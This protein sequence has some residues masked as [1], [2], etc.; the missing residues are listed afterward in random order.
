VCPE[1]QAEQGVSAILG[2]KL[3]QP[4]NLFR[5]GCDPWSSGPH[6]AVPQ[7]P[8]EM[9]MTL[10]RTIRSTAAILALSLA[11]LGAGSIATASSAAA[12]GHGHGH[13]G[14]GHGHGGHGGHGHGGHG[15]W[16]GWGP[17]WGG[18]IYIGVPSYVGYGGCYYVKKKVFVPGVG[19]VKQK[20]LVCN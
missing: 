5:R 18:G 17:A 9:K 16:G 14:H 4:M 12:H 1:S 13:G 3:P 11:T 2:K 15:P 19:K 7:D 8:S 6:R 20:V 10:S